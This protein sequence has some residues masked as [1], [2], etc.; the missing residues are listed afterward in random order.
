M[1]IVKSSTP[2]VLSKFK[3][4][5]S[6]LAPVNLDRLKS[7]HVSISER[8][9]NDELIDS[10]IKSIQRL[11]FA[12]KS[13]L[14]FSSFQSGFKDRAD[15]LLKLI[16]YYGNYENIVNTHVNPG[17]YSRKR[18]EY[19]LYPGNAVN[20]IAEKPVHELVHLPTG[21]SPIE[22]AIWT[23][24][25]V[26]AP[27][28][29]R[30]FKQMNSLEN[31]NS[32]VYD[33]ELN[34]IEFDPAYYE[35]FIEDSSSAEELLFKG[36]RLGRS[37]N[38][39]CQTFY[40]KYFPINEDTV[41]IWTING[42]SDPAPQ[43]WT[44]VN[45]LS[46]SLSTD[47][48]VYV[49][50]DLGIV[51]FGGKLGEDT[52]L[53]SPVLDTD[54]EITVLDPRRLPPKGYI[55]LIHQN[56]DELIYYG[57]INGFKL[58]NL[59]RTNPISF[60][61][62][63]ETI[64]SVEPRGRV[65]EAGATVLAFYKAVPRIE[66]E[67]NKPK[68]FASRS[69]NNFLPYWSNRLNT[70][71]AVDRKNKS[72]AVD[73]H[74]IKVL[75]AGKLYINQTVF[76]GPFSSRSGLVT[77]QGSV[78]DK[79][80]NPIVNSKVTIRSERGGLINNLEEAV[81][82]T[83]TQGHYWFT[84]RPIDIDEMMVFNQ[85]PDSFSV[86]HDFHNGEETTLITFQSDEAI[87]FSDLNKM[88]LYAVTK[89]SSSQ[90]TVGEK[91]T[92][93]GLLSIERAIEHTPGIQSISQVQLGTNGIVLPGTSILDTGIE[94]VGGLLKVYFAD[95]TTSEHFITKTFKANSV[96]TGDE[97]ID[98]NTWV[99]EVDSSIDNK[100]ISHVRLI[101]V[102]EV[103]WNP[104]ELNGRKTVLRRVSNDPNW[105]HPSKENAS[106]VHKPITPIEYLGGNVFRFPEYLPIPDRYDDENKLGAY[107]LFSGIQDSIVAEAEDVTCSK[108]KILSNK[109]FLLI[110]LDEIDNGT[111]SFGGNYVPYG[112]RI[113][114]DNM[115]VASTIS[116][117]T[118][119]TI[120][121]ISSFSEN[122]PLISYVDNNQI[123]YTEESNN[124]I[125]NKITYSIQVS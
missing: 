84:Y 3:K 106:V 70:I 36:D 94:Y 9:E 26:K 50:R 121:D 56:N 61:N 111:F 4:N 119:L 42:V 115:E 71:L 24:D 102:E 23:R 114:D 39:D 52:V 7:K 80:G 16:Q 91:Y 35:E 83:N 57:A 44:V 72:I 92:Y 29:H 76:F 64:V 51:Q 58:V 105:I 100:V 11:D 45:D 81:V 97:F 21:S 12:S 62:P 101:G 82:H 118:Y 1:S 40:S 122:E 2:V 55:R 75:N 60:L 68:L 48:H 8:I 66:Y 125:P 98:F 103:V 116:L 107:G 53:T 124:P 28:H 88:H 27:I 14:P 41:S 22:I 6:T 86:V 38:T 46:Q 18:Y 79:E 47:Y 96:N 78:L 65:P 123:I 37:D 33:D 74:S 30:R 67:T 31:K 99:V 10:N 109:V 95:N 5:Q 93:T 43:Q 120:N 15:G 73:G 87:A 77:L 17:F 112:F 113:A 49:D 54:E 90:G 85:E 19:F 104:D 108:R 89:D 25:R 32:Y 110:E 20:E 69:K 117:A 34:E 59:T 63:E 13:T